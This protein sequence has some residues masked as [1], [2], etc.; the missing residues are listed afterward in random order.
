[1]PAHFLSFANRRYTGS[2]VRI[3]AEARGM[4]RFATVAAVAR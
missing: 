3:R 1:M 2:L 4:G